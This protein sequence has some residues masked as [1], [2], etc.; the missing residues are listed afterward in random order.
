[1]KLEFRRELSSLCHLDP[2]HGLFSVS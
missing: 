1:L 2:P